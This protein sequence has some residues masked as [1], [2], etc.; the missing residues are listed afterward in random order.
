MVKRG[1]R[2]NGAKEPAEGLVGEIF[3]WACFVEGY[4]N[5]VFLTVFCLCFV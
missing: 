2:N 3:P 1:S 5:A 4:D